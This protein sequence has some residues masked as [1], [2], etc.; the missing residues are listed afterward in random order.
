MLETA[1]GVDMRY[2]YFLALISVPAFS[3]DASET[4]EETFPGVREVET[5]EEFKPHFGLVAGIV[6]PRQ[7]FNAAANF[8]LEAGF[9]PV[10]PFGLA[11]E[12]TRQE[13]D[14]DF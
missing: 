6:D 10:I 7:G 11:L 13:S 12:L 2:L 3:Q 5:T 1:E 4:L 8:G 14:A 9:Q